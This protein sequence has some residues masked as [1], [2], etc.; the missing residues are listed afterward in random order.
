MTQ[1]QE[2]QNDMN[3]ILYPSTVDKSVVIKQSLH[4]S[5][6]EEIKIYHQEQTSDWFQVGPRGW[7]H[8]PVL[9]DE[10]EDENSYEYNHYGIDKETQ[11]IIVAG[12]GLMNGNAYATIKV[13]DESTVLYREYGPKAWSE[14]YT[15]S[16]LKYSDEGFSFDVVSNT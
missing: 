14:L 3:S 13:I 4:L 7:D 15:D 16:M 12:G 5:L 6:M 9:D 1:Y 2:M 10:S 11:E 8:T